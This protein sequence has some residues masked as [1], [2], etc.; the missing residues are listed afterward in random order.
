MKPLPLQMLQGRR[1]GLSG[2]GGPGISRPLNGPMSASLGSEESPPSSGT[3]S[4]LEA[5]WLQPGTALAQ[6]LKGFLTSRPLYQHSSN[7]LQGLQLHQDYRAQKDFSTWAGKGHCHVSPGNKVGLL[8]GDGPWL[9]LAEA[10]GVPASTPGVWLG[11]GLGKGWAGTC[12]QGVTPG[13]RR[14]RGGE[15]SIRGGW[16]ICVGLAAPDY[17]YLSH[18]TAR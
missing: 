5:L 7:F 1:G 6:M 11:G 10:W 15:C 16:V 17:C 8:G 4:G 3:S 18:Q 2:E 9:G 14:G 12:I 13:V